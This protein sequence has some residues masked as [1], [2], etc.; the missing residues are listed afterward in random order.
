MEYKISKWKYYNSRLF[1]KY[2]AFHL[3]LL[4]PRSGFN[5]KMNVRTAI[6]L[7]EMCSIHSDFILN[8]ICPLRFTYE[9]LPRLLHFTSLFR[10]QALSGV[11]LTSYEINNSLYL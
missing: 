3:N 4:K 5:N 7:L 1:W 9:G 6:R 11:H 8:W 2:I 10:V